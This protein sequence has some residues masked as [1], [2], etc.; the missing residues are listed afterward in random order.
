ADP[1]ASPS[2][3]PELWAALADVW[4]GF[5]WRL[6]V[7][8]EGGATAAGAPV[9]VQ[10]RGPFAWLHALPWLLPA[11]P[12]AR[13]GAHARADPA[14]AGALGALAGE[15][16]AVGGTWSL[17]RPEGPAPPESA[18]AGVPGETRAFE[19]ALLRLGDG[20]R[21]LASRMSRKQRQAIERS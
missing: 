18:L 8:E 10:R 21:T 19:A 9:I 1:S 2:H 5:A 15:W 6:L 20:L 11:P 13:P 7:L 4:P 16:R 17:Y 14:I 12:I 3:R